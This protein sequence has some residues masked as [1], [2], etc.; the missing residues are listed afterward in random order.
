LSSS[1]NVYISHFGILL[2]FYA[3]IQNV[4][5]QMMRFQSQRRESMKMADAL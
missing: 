5:M 1:T 4:K 2:H 3:V